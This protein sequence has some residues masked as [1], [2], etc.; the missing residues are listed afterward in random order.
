MKKANEKQ[1]PKITGKTLHPQHAE[2]LSVIFEDLLKDIYWAEKHLTKALP[3]MAKAAHGEDL[4]AGFTKHLEETK[5]Q[6][7]R[8]EKV[9]E[10]MGKKAAAKKCAAMEGL[11][12]E[13]EEAIEEYEEGFARDASL[14]VAAQKVEHYEIAAYG[15]LRTHATLLGLNEAAQLL[16]E[17]LHEEKTT[18]QTLT[19][20]SE[21]I[22]EWALQPEEAEA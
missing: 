20:L 4:K 5:N 14:I 12:K 7:T 8:L 17:T 21:T 1:A 6:V 16:E 15:S 10:L 13:G 11:V 3:K 18:D 22:N 19:T 2:D 9:F